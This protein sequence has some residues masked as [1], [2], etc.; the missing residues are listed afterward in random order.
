[1][2]DSRNRKWERKSGSEGRLNSNCDHRGGEQQRKERQEAKTGL[3]D[4]RPVVKNSAV[5]NPHLTTCE[6]IRP[7][8]ARTAKSVPS[9]FIPRAMFSPLY[10]HIPFCL[11]P[12]PTVHYSHIQI[13]VLVHIRAIQENKSMQNNILKYHTK[14]K[15]IITQ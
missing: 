9:L 11:F 13:N 10:H 2:V 3:A 1:M 7:R 8:E 4:P 5:I 6:K 15:C 14:K 12:F